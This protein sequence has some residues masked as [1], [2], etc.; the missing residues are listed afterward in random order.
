MANI[1][2]RPLPAALLSGTDPA[3]VTLSTSLVLATLRYNLANLSAHLDA[4]VQGRTV[5]HADRLDVH[6]WEVI[7]R[8]ISPA[9]IMVEEEKTLES[10]VI[11]VLR[12][13][14][15]CSPRVGI[16]I[17]ARIWDVVVF[18]GDAALI[19]A[20]VAVLAKLESRLYGDRLEILKELSVDDED[21]MVQ[22]WILG[23]TED[24]MA[25]MKEMGKVDGD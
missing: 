18:E 9:S 20:A 1:L 16:E 3:T 25:T 17:S 22:K 21:A 2:H 11:P 4:T 23:E 24:F 19:R 12:A 7:A 13:V 5:H 14:A 15:S 8:P 10:L 6:D